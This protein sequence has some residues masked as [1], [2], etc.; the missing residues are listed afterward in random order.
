[1][2]RCACLGLSAT[3]FLIFLYAPA[4]AQGTSA[5]S[6]AGVVTDATGAVLP[7]VT[8]EAAS[9]SLI[10]RL[11]TAVTNE[12][13]LYRIIELKPGSYTVTFTLTGFATVKREGIELPPNFT[14]TVNAELKVGALEETVTVSGQS[15]LVD[16]Q[17][18]TRQTVIPKLLLDTVPTGKNLLSF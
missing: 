2:Y 14:A 4:S 9:P 18:V 13:G 16:T 8:V 15:P 1:M 11:R 5:A 7:G 3:A 10:E 12:Q 17:N 6:I